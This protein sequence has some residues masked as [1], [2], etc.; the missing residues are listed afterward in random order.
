MPIDDLS[1]GLEYAYLDPKI[2]SMKALAGTTFDPSVNTSS[3]YAVGQSI[4]NVFVLPYASK[5]SVTLNADYTFIHFDGGSMAANL[6]YRWKSSYFNTAPAGSAV[7]GRENY[8]VPSY[9]LL[10][11]RL[12]MSLDLPKQDKVKVSLWGRNILNKDYPQQVIG[13]GNAIDTPAASAGYYSQAKIWAE[14]ASYG[15]DINYQY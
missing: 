11:A 3:P 8:E 6:N 4:K 1:I 2:D 14:P 5:N 15:I 10:D 12:T 13:L 7:P 9:W